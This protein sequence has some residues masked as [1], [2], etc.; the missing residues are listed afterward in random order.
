MESSRLLSLLVLF[1]FFVNFQGPVV[2]YWG[3]SN[4]CPKVKEKCEYKER[5]R[6]TEDSDCMHNKKC[7]V[8]SCGKKCFDIQQDVCTMPKEPGPCMAFFERWWYNKKNNTCS[9]FIYGGCLGNN[10]N[11]QSIDLCL[12]MCR[13]KQI[14]P[15]IRVK[16]EFEEVNQCTK[17]RHCPENLKCCW[18]GCGKKCVDLRKGN[19]ET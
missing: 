4:K 16:C 18:L 15:K 5:D 13:K 1:S 8:F 17:N 14:C 2:S 9:I 7:C 10:N 3:F 6:C 19:S 12:N 11:F